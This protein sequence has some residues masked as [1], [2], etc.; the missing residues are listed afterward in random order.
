MAGSHALQAIIPK[1][2]ALRRVGREL[3][4]GLVVTFLLFG[5]YL[6]QFLRAGPHIEH[7]IKS[8]NAL[9]FVW[10]PHDVFALWGCM[11]CLAGSAVAARE[12]L[13]RCQRAWL[14]RCFDHVFVVMLGA[15]ILTNLWFHT[16]RPHG[17][18]IGQF[19]MEMQTAW[20]LLV[21]VAGYSLASPGSPL[22]RWC[23]RLCQIVSPAILIV[24]WQLLQLPTLAQRM[25]SLAPPE[26]PSEHCT[27]Q[28]LNGSRARLTRSD[29]SSGQVEWTSATDPLEAADGPVYLFIF[30]EWSY[31]RTYE[32][33][34]CRD[35]LANIAEISQ[36]STTF[37]DAHSVS[38]RTLYSIPG[39][40][41]GTTDLAEI[42]DFRPGFVR[43]G[44][45]VP[46]T[47]YPSVF[48]RAG[49]A[50]YRKI[51]LQWGFAVSFWV[52]DELDVSRSYSCYPRGNNPAT[53]AAI[54]LYN[55]AFY[56]T[57]PWTTLVYEKL[58]GRILD[59]H[60]LRMYDAFRRDTKELI[61][62][63]PTRSFAII[64]YPIP[65]PPYILNPDGS[66]RGR[67]WEDNKCGNEEG[68]ER[69][70]AYLDRLIGEFVAELK[71]TG[72]YDQSLLIL[73]SD[74]SWRQDPAVSDPTTDQ[75]THVPLIIKLPG[76]TEPRHINERFSL[77]RLGELIRQARHGNLPPWP[78]SR[79]HRP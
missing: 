53:D 30:D 40:L 55:A 73:T 47:E 56:W 24:T 76:Q 8:R 18:H 5:P 64:H 65:H 20:L 29:A 42:Q 25:D 69:N 26:H 3:L 44:V 48:T 50:D 12:I 36:H 17:Y 10:Q 59:G 49:C 34:R 77:H 54:H 6:S 62:H 32:A 74:H 35:T 7:M 79:A 37:H 70:L 78:G 51:M 39:M 19:G 31:R 13:R 75:L 46:C 4:A 61:R 63:Q 1:K 16:Q 15:A 71:A 22:V 66:Y 67:N 28:C 43:D 33:G 57:D 11:L 23:T 68:Y 52:D 14:V 60:A 27:P 41:R 2:D 38:K 21:A 9:W 45:F 58:K 72:R